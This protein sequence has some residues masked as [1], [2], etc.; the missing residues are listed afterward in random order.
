MTSELSESFILCR[1]ALTRGQLP[2][3]WS[4][5]VTVFGDLAQKPGA[6][7]SGTVLGQITEPV[8]IRPEAMRVALHRLRRD[9]WLDSERSGRVSYHFLTEFGRTQSVGANDRIYGKD[10]RPMPEVHVL[11][12]GDGDA[13]GR[14]KLDAH[15][16]TDTLLPLGG[17]AAIGLGPAP[18][19][20][21]GLLVMTPTADH[22]PDW[23]KALIGPEETAEAYAQLMEAMRVL[24]ANIKK[25]PAFSPEQ[26]ASLRCLLVHEWRRV[27][28]RHP[29]F[30][31]HFFPEGWPGLCCRHQV[32]DLLAKMAV[33]TDRLLDHASPSA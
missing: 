30:P 10:L 23:L 29:D 19:D 25:W 20:V 33:S 5:I 24:E 32:Q 4:L 22:L 15:L 17:N 9:G 7:I 3:V 12:A 27:V 16:L 8:G 1:D 2:R 11:M 26:Q 14:R 31:E 28:L 13:C 21:E 18:E 6:R